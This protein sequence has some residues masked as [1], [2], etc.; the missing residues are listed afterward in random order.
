MKHFLIG[1]LILMTP[2]PATA[3]DLFFWSGTV[4]GAKIKLFLLRFVSP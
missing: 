3:E 2:L 4:G 1:V